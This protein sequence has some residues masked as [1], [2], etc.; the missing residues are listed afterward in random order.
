[1]V[2]IEKLLYLIEDF[3]ERGN[4]RMYIRIPGKKKVRVP[5]HLVNQKGTEE[6]A[7]FYW[8]IRRGGAE[9][10]PA[11][12]KPGT[13][14]WL[15]ELYYASQAFA[16]LD[17]TYTQVERRRQLDPLVAKIGHLPALI[18]T[19]KIKEAQSTRKRSTQRKFVSALRHLYQTGME[20]GHVDRDPTAGIKV[21]KSKTEGHKTWPVEYCLRYEKHWP[22]GTQQRTAYAIAL[23]LGARRSDAV[24]I[25][26]RQEENGGRQVRYIQH[27]GRQAR[28]VEVVHPI[29]PPLR[30]ALD[31]WQGG[32]FTWLETNRKL[33]RSDKAFGDDFSRWCGEAGVP[34]GYTYHG[35]RKALAARLAEAGN[36]TNEINA[37]LGDVTLQQAEIYTRAAEKK[38]MATKALTGLFGE[39]TVP[40]ART[41]VKRRKKS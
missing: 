4:K 24:R 19:K 1:M 22:L 2:G 34:K 8:E 16:D 10:K 25:G 21:K 39:Q 38:K 40:V 13:L 5:E 30:E 35:L 23:Y 11:K 20:L 3:D 36:S 26:I 33:P 14:A 27:K 15:V 9:D 31:A 32:R 18:P 6:F 37:V 7:L 17:K 29:V 12:A 28:S 41:G